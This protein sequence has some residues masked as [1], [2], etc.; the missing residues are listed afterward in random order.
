MSDTPLLSAQV[1]QVLSI[2]YVKFVATMVLIWSDEN[3]SLS[4]AALQTQVSGIG[5]VMDFLPRNQIDLF[6]P[7]S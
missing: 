3:L 5:T 2:T 6:F 1:I 7:F 4:I